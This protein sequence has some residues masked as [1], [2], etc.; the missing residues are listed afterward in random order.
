MDQ[1]LKFNQ[2]AL[3]TW[4]ETSSKSARPQPTGSSLGESRL[5]PPTIVPDWTTQTEWAFTRPD[6]RLIQPVTS[7]DTGNRP[8][9]VLVNKVLLPWRNAL[10]F[11]E[12]IPLAAVIG[13]DDALKH[14]AVQVDYQVAQDLLP[15]E[16]AF[17]LATE[18]GPAL[19]YA[20]TSI[21]TSQRFRASVGTGAR[22]LGTLGP[23]L[24][25]ALPSAAS[26]TEASALFQAREAAAETAR[27]IVQ[28]ELSE[29]LPGLNTP[30]QIQARFGT[31]LDVLAKANIRQAQAEG[32]L[33]NTLVTSPTVSISRGYLASRLDPSKNWIKAPDVWDTATGR[34]WDFMAR[35]EAAFYQHGASYLGTTAFGRRDPTGTLIT[36]IFPLFHSGF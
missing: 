34:A 3:L 29:G 28:Q 22:A 4:S 26:S 17:G 32:R 11:A 33:S 19:E 23:K 21:S 24:E 6:P 18:L 2:I 25:S 20:V 31:W 13:T 14:S 8:L 7:V 9:N 15:A 16:G 1:G 27:K 36:E 30:S 10:A 5:A 35:N 12:N